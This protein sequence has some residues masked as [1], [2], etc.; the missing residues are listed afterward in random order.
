M[1]LELTVNGIAGT[2]RLWPHTA[3]DTVAALVASLPLES[4][5]KQCRWSGDASFT[6]LPSGPI[7]GVERLEAPAVTIYPGTLVVRLA[8]PASPHAELLIGYGSAE[9]RWPDGPKPVTP[10][11]EICSQR[12]ELFREMRAIAM[13]GPAP[14]TLHVAERRA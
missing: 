5:L 8:E 6:D 2:V 14:V 13:T 7:T 11:G 4:E 10:V 12:A 1:E 3:P 9:H